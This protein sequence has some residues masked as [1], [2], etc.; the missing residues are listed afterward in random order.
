M[1][2]IAAD[3]QAEITPSNVDVFQTRT[4]FIEGNIIKLPAAAVAAIEI[5]LKK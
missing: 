4:E 2:Y 5:T 3:P 1:E